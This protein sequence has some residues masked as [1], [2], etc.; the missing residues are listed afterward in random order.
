M[1]FYNTI[2]YDPRK[3]PDDRT[4]ISIQLGGIS[5]ECS[6]IKIAIRLGVYTLDET[7]SILF[8]TFL[9]DCVTGQPEDYNENK[10]WAAISGGVYTPSTARG[11]TIRSTTYRLLHHLISISLMH[12]KNSKRVPSTDL[13]FLSTLLTPR[14]H[15]NLPI[16]LATYMGR[17][18]KGLQEDSLIC[19][20]QFITRLDRSYFLL[21]RDIMRSMV[22]Y[23]ARL[24]CL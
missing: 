4:T 18:A 3:T 9:V 16:K 5:R 23:E 8:P 24:T 12:H 21:T 20:G 1:E 14:R 6:V 15:L 7:R 13:F 19:G 11:K 22:L 10:F 2:S 17:R